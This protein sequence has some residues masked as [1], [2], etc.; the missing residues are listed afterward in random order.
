MPILTIY[1]TRIFLTIKV[2]KKKKAKFLILDYTKPEANF[3]TYAGSVE[4]SEKQNGPVK[5]KLISSLSITITNDAHKRI[6][7][8]KTHVPKALL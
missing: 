3:M 6:T 8:P 1:S 2:L 5:K 4:G 7:L